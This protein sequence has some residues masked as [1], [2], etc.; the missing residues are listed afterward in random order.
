VSS[1]VSYPDLSNV[2]AVV[3]DDVVSIEYDVGLVL[4]SVRDVLYENL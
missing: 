4:D 1:Y 2:C 3:R